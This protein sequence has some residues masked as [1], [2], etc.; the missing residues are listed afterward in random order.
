MVNISDE[1]GNTPLH[2]ACLSLQD[3]IILILF[4][5]SSVDTSIQNHN[6]KTARDLLATKAK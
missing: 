3:Q 5:H 4:E 6:G 2:V 1:D